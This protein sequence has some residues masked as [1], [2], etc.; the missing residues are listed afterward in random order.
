MLS[1]SDEP[2]SDSR[3][4]TISSYSRWDGT[5][6]PTGLNA[7]EMLAALSDSLLA[8]GIEQALDRALHRGLPPS[9][10]DAAGLEGLDALR[11]RLRAERKRLE[12]ADELRDAVERL[13]EELASRGGGSEQLG[14]ESSRLL[15]ALAANPELARQLLARSAVETRT[16]LE[17]TLQQ[18]R[19]Q[20]PETSA[21]GL[22]ATLPFAG[23][24]N[25]ADTLERLRALTGLEGHI[26]RVRRVQDVDAVDPGLVRALLG[27]EAGD[28]LARLAESLQTFTASGYLRRSGSRLEL[29]ARALQ[30]IGDDLLSAVFAQMLGRGEGEHLTRGLPSGHDL[31]GTTRDYDFGDP[32][33]LD[34]SRTVLQAVKRGAGTPVQLTPADFAIFEREETARASTVLAIDISR[35]MGERGYLLAAKKLALAL[36]T[37]LRAR[38]PRDRLSLVAFSESAR[39]LTPAELPRL[40]WDRYG[41][42]TNVHDALRLARGVLS[43]QRGLQRSIVLITDGEPT[44]HRDSAGTVHF[45]HPPS[46]ETVARTYAEAE[47]CRRDGIRLTICV[48]SDQP[49]VVRFA[50]ELARRAAGV[51]VTTS[52]A[53]LSLHVALQYGRSRSV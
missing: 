51:V 34:L 26:R 8:G 45:S 32:L 19:G 3:Q 15:N 14:E 46:P 1:S 23:A 21:D 52:P 30:R 4:P 37:L 12:D 28:A 42:G 16:T 5:Q 29:S 25:A 20:L 18:L 9:G 48:L 22:D 17:A 41:Y 24:T 7:E 27:D 50:A 43:T 10:D 53:D 40:N 47:R 6:A 39:S 44:A 33:S 31:T 13:A 36:N 49:Q 11:D 38:F 2:S 35:S